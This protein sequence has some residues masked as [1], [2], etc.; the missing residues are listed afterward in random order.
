MVTE[1]FS[2]PSLLIAEA[3]LTPQSQ[4]T[5]LVIVSAS[6]TSLQKQETLW[7]KMGWPGPQKQSVTQ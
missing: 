2:A 7:R 5:I 3:D 6:H 1:E 4:R